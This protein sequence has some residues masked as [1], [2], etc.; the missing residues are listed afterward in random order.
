MNS[1]VIFLG[2]V[3]TVSAITL[4][5]KIAKIPEDEIGA[6]D[7]RSGRIAYHRSHCEKY[8][9]YIFFLGA[10]LIVWGLGWA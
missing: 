7:P 1:I 9:V 5:L 4:C 3:C 2:I 8:G 6:V 10:V